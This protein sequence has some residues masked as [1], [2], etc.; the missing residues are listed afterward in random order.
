MKTVDFTKKQSRATSHYSSGRWWMLFSAV[1]YGWEDMRECSK[2]FLI[3]E[4]VE[5]DL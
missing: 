5:E 3:K 1:L 2:Y 4:I